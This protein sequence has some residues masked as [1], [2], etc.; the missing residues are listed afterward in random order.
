MF[1]R[2]LLVTWTLR[3][4]QTWGLIKICQRKRE[5][6]STASSTNVIGSHVISATDLHSNWAGDLS[7]ATI[8]PTI[9]STIQKQVSNTA[10]NEG[11]FDYHRSGEAD[12]SLLD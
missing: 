8:P 7:I 11:V 3:R 5:G 9:I 12:V 10:C 1:A 6:L 4:V 2:R